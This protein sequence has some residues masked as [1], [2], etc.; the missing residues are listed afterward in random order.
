LYL[1]SKNKGIKDF[2]VRFYLLGI[3]A[4]MLYVPSKT[5]TKTNAK[6]KI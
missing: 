3:S 1:V 6:T 4:T 5:K 2:V